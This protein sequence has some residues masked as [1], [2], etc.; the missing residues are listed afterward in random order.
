MQ[1]KGD[2]DTLKKKRLVRECRQSSRRYSREADME[3]TTYIVPQNIIETLGRGDDLESDSGKS[4]STGDFFDN[5]DSLFEQ[6]MEE[7]ITG[8]TLSY[9][10]SLLVEDNQ[11]LEFTQ[12]VKAYYLNED[13]FV[14]LLLFCNQAVDGDQT[15]TH[16]EISNLYDS[17]S[18]AMRIWHS[19]DKE[20]HQL[21][22][23]EL[24]ETIG[25]GAFNDGRGYILTQETKDNLLGDLELKQS[26][27]KQSRD[28][29][30]YTSIT[31]KE[32]R[33][34]K[35]ETDKIK[36]LQSLL[37][38]DNYK[39]VCS[40][41][42]SGNMRLGFTCLFSGGP[43]TGKTDTVL[44]LARL[45]RRDIMKVDIAATK[46][47]WF[48]ESEKI[49]KGVFVRYRQRVEE[50]EKKGYNVPVLFFN[51]ADGVLGRRQTFGG[52]RS[53]AAQTENA[54]QNIIL[55]EME[56]ISGIMI[57][58]T[59]LTANLD[60]AFE[61]RFLY[62][63]EFSKPGPESR[64]GIWK[65]MIPELADADTETLASSF[66]FSG[67]QIENIVRKRAIDAV[68]SGMPPSLEAMLAMCRE[69]TLVKTSRPIGFYNE[70]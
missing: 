41:L 12:K 38:E 21:Q 59:N 7:S 49:I 67:G 13:S 14:L 35:D 8:D 23:S 40:R 43:G 70:K 52:E 10:I 34:N 62:K 17:R 20:E 6:R 16:Q 45:S 15:I 55:D 56:N 33:Y 42:N 46:T 29:I 28:I 18:R 44:Q 27:K 47:K 61:R 11:H 58:T 69:E 63:I 4:L 26:E 48:G 37:S 53:G 2:F 5:L 32:L 39:Q 64:K 65:S 30:E 36:R 25:R 9:E 68:L 1:Y 54:I 19:L 57:A 60:N 31:P 51:E 66:E 50:A 24:I 22:K 3:I